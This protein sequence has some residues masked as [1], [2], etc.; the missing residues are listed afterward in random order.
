MSTYGLTPEVRALRERVRRFIDEEVGLT[1]PEV[2]GSDPT[3]MQSAARLEGDHWVVN[4]HKWFTSGA[5]R[6]AF[7]TIFAITE[8]EAAP[9][10]RFSAIIVPTDAP[11]YEI[12]RVVPTMGHTG[13]AHCE[14][15]LSDVRVP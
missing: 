9:H 8:P 4:A 14:I 15:R 6:A 3:L 5:N 7:T 10:Q 12:V 11:G 13:G 2:A 1:E